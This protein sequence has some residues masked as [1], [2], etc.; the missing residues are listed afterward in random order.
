MTRRQAQYVALCDRIQ[1]FA[2]FSSAELLARAK[3][4]KMDDAIRMDMELR[5]RRDDS[6]RAGR[7][8]LGSSRYAEATR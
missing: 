2:R 7:H 4:A 1:E 3:R 5:R 6:R 8:G